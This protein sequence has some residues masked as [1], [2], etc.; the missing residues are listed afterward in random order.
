MGCCDNCKKRTRKLVEGYET[1][2][3]SVYT[4]GGMLFRDKRNYCAIT[5]VPEVVKKK[6]R[7]GQ[8]KSKR[9]FV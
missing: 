8:K 5:D 4:V 6:I 2:L 9:Q 1:K 3:C 7:V